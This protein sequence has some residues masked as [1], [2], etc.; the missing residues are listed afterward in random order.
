M[1]A[2]ITRSNPGIVPVTTV[3]AGSPKQVA[4]AC[5]DPCVAAIFVGRSA[6]EVIVG[7]A[8]NRAGAAK[9]SS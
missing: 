9:W 4:V 3:V 7:D 6:D 1:N 8:A 5:A 2:S